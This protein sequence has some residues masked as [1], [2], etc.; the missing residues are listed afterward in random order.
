MNALDGVKLPRMPPGIS[1]KAARNLGKY[2][3][4]G[5]KCQGS[6]LVIFGRG[7]RPR[8]GVRSRPVR[9]LLPQGTKTVA[10]AHF[11]QTAR[12]EYKSLRVLGH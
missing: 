3:T 4:F 9:H 12:T 2:I 5:N 11:S 1:H 10:S 8:Q 7:S 6:R